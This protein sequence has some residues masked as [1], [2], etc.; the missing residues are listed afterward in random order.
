MQVN[1]PKATHSSKIHSKLV[2]DNTSL[3]RITT[4]AANEEVSDLGTSKLCGVDNLN[5]CY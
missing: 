5:L 4:S 2:N 3:D 1:L